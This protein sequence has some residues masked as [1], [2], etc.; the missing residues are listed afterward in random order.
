MYSFPIVNLKT[1]SA[2]NFL[3]MS[4]FSNSPAEISIVAFRLVNHIWVSSA[5][6]ATIS[7]YQMMWLAGPFSP[8]PLPGPLPEGLDSFPE[9]WPL[10]GLGMSELYAEQGS[11]STRRTGSSALNNSGLSPRKYCGLQRICRKPKIH[12]WFRE[13]RHTGLRLTRHA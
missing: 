2:V 10:S 6:A 12:V 5:R 13:S 11:R 3:S 4:P 8:R 7:T 1:L 9:G